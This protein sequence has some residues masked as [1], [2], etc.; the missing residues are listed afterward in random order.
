MEGFYDSDKFQFV[1]VDF[2]G[3]KHLAP[4]HYRELGEK[5]GGLYSKKVSWSDVVINAVPLEKT[6]EFEDD[7][8]IYEKEYSGTGIIIVNERKMKPIL[9]ED[10][11]D[12]QYKKKWMNRL[13]KIVEG[14][15][16]LP[17]A[18]KKRKSVERYPVKP[19]DKKMVRD[20]KIFKSSEK[21]E[22]LTD[23]R[24]TEHMNKFFDHIHRDGEYEDV[25][26]FIPGE[27]SSPEAGWSEGWTTFKK[28]KMTPY[29]PPEHWIKPEILWEKIWTQM[30]E[31]EYG[32]KRDYHYIPEGGYDSEGYP[33]PSIFFY[34][35]NSD[36][37][38]YDFNWASDFR[39]SGPFNR[40]VSFNL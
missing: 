22:E 36:N 33:G 30:D 31:L 28:K 2:D 32:W 34:D 40:W 26:I 1:E 10:E 37:L 20:E 21:F 15:I 11:G 5:E 25:P 27:M 13:S 6:F 8:P 4:V 3:V 16:N 29:Y 39:Y 7:Q 14:P 12:Y 35:K 9:S 24:D 18:K 17:E 38:N 19:K 23:E